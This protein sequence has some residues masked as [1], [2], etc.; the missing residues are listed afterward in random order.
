[1]RTMLGILAGL[2]LATGACRRSDNDR[3][4]DDNSMRNPVE[5]IQPQP[6]QPG[7]A[8]DETEAPTGADMGGDEKAFEDRRKTYS[9]RAHQR[10][11]R[12]E[13]RIAELEA[14]GDE[15]SRD[16]AARLRARQDEARTKMS[17]VR[18]RARDGWNEFEGDMTRTFDELEH[19]VEDAFRPSP[20]PDDPVQ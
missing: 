1:M 7:I 13:A 10:L 9:D 17:S 16:L 3:R 14:R 5:R 2:V 6:S 4:S 20:A 15:V 18:E 8:P 11:D 19:E 12:I